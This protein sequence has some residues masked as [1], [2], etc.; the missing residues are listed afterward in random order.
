MTPAEY[1]AC[2]EEHS[3]AL[4]RYALRH[5]RCRDQAHD[6]VQECFLRLWMKLDKV[7]SGKGRSY[8]FTMAHNLMVSQARRSGRVLRMEPWH[9]QVRS[10]R[11]GE[12]DL[13]S[14]LERGLARLPQAQ[15]SV[16]VLRDQEGHSYEEIAEITGLSMDQVKVYIF[17]GRKAMQ[18]YLGSPAMVA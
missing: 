3:D 9:E 5:T 13:K 4:F 8:L 10:C 18:R 2:V 12:P 16:L 7:E 11:Q 17:R 15:R 14:L 1:N 6:V